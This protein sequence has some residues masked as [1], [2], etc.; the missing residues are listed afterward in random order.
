[1]KVSKSKIALGVVGVLAAVTAFCSFTI[2][3]D[4]TVK[5]E[6]FMGK[7]NPVP[8]TAGFNFHKPFANVN[9]FTVRDILLDFPKVPVPSQDK[10]VSQIDISVMVKFDGNKAPVVRRESGALQSESIQKYVTQRL[11]SVINEFGKTVPVAQDFYNAEIQ[12]GLQQS[13]MMEVNRSAQLYGYTI[14]RV[15]IKR[16]YLPEVVQAQVIKTKEREEEI[17]QERAVLDKVK[18]TAQQQVVKATAARESAEQNALA[19]ERQAEAV[20][21]ATEQAAEAKL[22]AAQ[23]EAEGNRVL[24]TTITPQ[25]IQWQQLAIDMKV[26]E[27]YQGHTPQTIVGAD[28]KGGLMLGGMRQETK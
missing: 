6:M 14:K 1:M 15:D 18:L 26:A 24:Q 9:T 13:I 25:V 28:F 2:V 20:R 10:Q 11:L 21:Y 4:G 16:V 3:D 5:T 8:M 27:K 12:S 19:Q 23:K 22:F 7:V 17:N